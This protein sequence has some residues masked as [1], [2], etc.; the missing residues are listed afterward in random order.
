MKECFRNSIRHYKYRTNIEAK[1]QNNRTI[2]NNDEDSTNLKTTTI[3]SLRQKD[4][5]KRK[6]EEEWSIIEPVSEEY[7][8]SVILRSQHIS[9]NDENVFNENA[10]SPQIKKR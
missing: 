9:K 5:L 2:S 7:H 1:K 4:Y 6:K 10:A 8:D 3:S